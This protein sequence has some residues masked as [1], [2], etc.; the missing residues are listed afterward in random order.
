MRLVFIQNWQNELGK[1]LINNFLRNSQNKIILADENKKV[2][3]D[4]GDEKNIEIL[5][6]LDSVKNFFQDQDENIFIFNT[7]FINELE[8]AD[9]N[10]ISELNFELQRTFETVKILCKNLLDANR[11]GKFIF[12]TVNPTLNLA[13]DFPIAP[14][15]DEAIH[16]FIKTLAKEMSALDFTFNAICL[17]PIFEMLTRDQIKSYRRKMQIYATR[18]NPVSFD[19]LFNFIEYVSLSTTNILSG[20]IFYIGSGMSEN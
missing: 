20:A 13:I 3:N 15:H 4:F 9:E 8:N 6:D 1:S 16:S 19:E 5:Q 14:I 7:K 10:Y 12:L 2:Y 11:K 17:E 18:K